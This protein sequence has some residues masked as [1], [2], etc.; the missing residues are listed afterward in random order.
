MNVLVEWLLRFREDQL[1]ILGTNFDAPGH[2]EGG[3][4]SIN[5]LVFAASDSDTSASRGWF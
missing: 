4:N 3:R 1:H 2:D 5:P